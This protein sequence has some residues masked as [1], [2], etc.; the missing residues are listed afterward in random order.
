MR[1]LYDYYRSSAAYRVRIALN[2]KGLD[3]ECIPVDLAGGEHRSDRYGEVNPQRLVPALETDAGLLTQSLAIIDYLEETHPGRPLLSGDAIVR[4]R[5]RAM[6]Q[7]IACDI[8][9]LNNLRVLNYLREEMRRPD[10]QVG[11]W[12]GHWIAAG[13][14]ALEVHAHETPF[15]GG[16]Q[17]ML[18]DVVLVPQMY[19]ARRFEVPLDPFPGL[20]AIAR[21]CN[22]I[23]AFTAAAPEECVVE[24]S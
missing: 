13:F 20:V 11:E 5:Q 12:Y 15:L 16:D 7:V 10:E 23:D 6:A 1:K 4:A 14:A 18:P 3:Y 9:P 8:H 2:L 17:P 22:E 21:R 24:G 19:N